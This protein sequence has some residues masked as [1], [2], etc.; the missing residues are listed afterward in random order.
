MMTGSEIRSIVSRRLFRSWTYT[1]LRTLYR[2]ARDPSY[3]R[4]KGN[5]HRFYRQFV[6]PGD[7][8]FDIGANIGDYT[9]T[10]ISLGARVVAVEP[11]AACCE[12]IRCLNRG[13]RLIVRCEAV[14]EQQGQCLLY[15]GSL[16]THSSISEAWMEK[17]VQKVPFLK[18][19][20]EL[21]ANVNT[22]DKIQDEH[23]TPQYIKID[24]EGYE[25]K[26]LRGMSFLPR[27]ISF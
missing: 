15:L 20:G 23:R 9:E 17:A 5:M 4:L 1:S 21:T 26:V 18:W 10:F 2:T 6:M 7:L 14:G 11:I 3:L 24:V 16:S 22:L 25:L 12:K 8:V 13:N 27:V 19:S